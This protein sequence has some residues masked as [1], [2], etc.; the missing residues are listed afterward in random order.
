MHEAK[1]APTNAFTETSIKSFVRSGAIAQIPEIK[2]T[3][4]EKLE[5]PHKA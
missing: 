4:L 5:K 1:V 2:I 3:T